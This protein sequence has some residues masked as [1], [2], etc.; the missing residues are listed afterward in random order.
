MLFGD[1]LCNLK[2]DLLRK[3]LFML[4]LIFVILAEH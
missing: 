2:I 3:V 1:A 4:D